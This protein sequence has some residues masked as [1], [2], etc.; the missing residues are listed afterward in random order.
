MISLPSGIFNLYYEATDFFINDPTIGKSIILYYETRKPKTSSI[1]NEDLLDNSKSVKNETLRVRMYHSPRD[2]LKT[3]HVDMVAGRVQ[4][5]GFMTDAIK[6]QRSTTI[7]YNNLTYK[8][9]VQP[10]PHG[11]GNRYFIAFLDLI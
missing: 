4:I 3:G 6:L 10:V 1:Y 9:A 8:L 2:W 11:F 5:I 7:K